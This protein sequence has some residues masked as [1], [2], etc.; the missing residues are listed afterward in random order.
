M[1]LPK[2]DGIN[3]KKL[4]Q[5]SKI[6]QSYFKSAKTHV[7]IFHSLRQFQVTFANQDIHCASNSLKVKNRNPTFLF[8][9]LFPLNLNLQITVNLFHISHPSICM[10]FYF[11]KSQKEKITK[12][13]GGKNQKKE[14]YPHHAVSSYQRQSWKEFGIEKQKLMDKEM[15]FSQNR[16]L[17]HRQVQ[18]PKYRIHP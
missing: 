2:T 18:L 16:C 8:L 15:I 5:F 14:N 4:I 7:I 13:A 11:P 10:D 1:P 12:M 17:H 9:F 3:L 6:C